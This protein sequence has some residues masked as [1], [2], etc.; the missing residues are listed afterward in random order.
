MRSRL[1]CYSCP[2]ALGSCPIGSLQAVLS[3]RNFHVSF[4]VAGFLVL[5]GAAL[6]KF[7]C[8][9]LC[10]FG[11]V[12]DL[13]YRIPFVKKLKKLPGD[14]ILQ[15]LKY[16]VL[17][18]L[19]LLLP[20]FAVDAFG[21]G[22]P[23]FC[24]YL[25]P[26]GTLMGGIPLFFLNTGIRSAVGFLYAYKLVLLILIL[27]LSLLVYRPFC[28]YLCPLGA[29]YGLFNPVSL[30]KYKIDLDKCIRCGKCRTVCKLDIDP[31]KTPNHSLCIRCGLCKSACP[32]GA[33]QFA[34]SSRSG[35]THAKKSS[36]KKLR[37]ISIPD[38]L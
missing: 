24:K 22:E 34:L 38:A 15:G 30:T 37:S 18:V 25:C 36:K 17:V 27:F 13:I 26:S 33:I 9:W 11:L 19:V 21:V 32:T 16:V 4:Y 8:G 12:Q 35:C 7:S 14:R 5:F 23:A 1:S 6:G 10:P 20:L 29:I 28:R 31:R 2:G 3:S